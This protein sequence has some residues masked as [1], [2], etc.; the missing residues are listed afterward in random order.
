M[1]STEESEDAV[2]QVTSFG[3]RPQRHGRKL[4][5]VISSIRHEKRAQPFETHKNDV[6]LYTFKNRLQL[7]RREM[8]PVRDQGTVIIL[9][10]L[11]Y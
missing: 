11:L 2:I 4:V 6:E 5:S 8:S 10:S 7:Q 3:S 9:L 1:A